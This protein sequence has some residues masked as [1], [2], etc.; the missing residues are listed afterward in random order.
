MHRTSAICSALVVVI[1]PML[2]RAEEEPNSV[3]R[4]ARQAKP[5][6]VVVSVDDRQGDRQ[7]RGTGFVVSDDGLIATSLHVIGEARP[8]WVNLHDDTQLEVTEV[9]ASDQSLD[10][11]ILRVPNTGKLTALNLADH[12]LTEGQ[13]VVAVG[14]PLGL[15]NTV[16]SGAVAG[17]TDSLGAPMWQVA[18]TI[19][20]G[21]SGGPLIDMQSNVHGVVAMK[22]VGSESF[23]FA[24]KVA[25]L[26][27]LLDHPNPIPIERW[28][29]IGQVDAS[30]W[31]AKM[32]ARWRQ[33]SGRLMVEEPGQG[34]GGRALLLRADEA[35]Q[36]P[37]EVSVMVKLDDE[38]GAAGLVFHSDGG[39]RHYGFYPSAGRIRF[40][41]F[42]GPTVFTWKVLE[43][44]ETEAYHRG[45]WN[46]L[47]VRVEQ[48]RIV[49]SVNGQAI[50]DVAQ[51]DLAPGRIGLC[52][53]RN[54]KPQFRAFRFGRSVPSR[55]PS[56]SRMT[57]L[58]NQLSGLGD[59]AALHDIDL[60]GH[61]SE[62]P[63]R[64]T[65]LDQQAQELEQRA[66]DLRRLGEDLHVLSVCDELSQ[67]VR[68]KSVRK[69]DLVRGALLIAKL[70]N[71][72]LNIETYV[73]AVD[74]MVDEIR[75]GFRD[76]TSAKEQLEALD[77]YLFK[78]NGFHG[79]RTEYYNAANSHLDR[80][81]DDR[82]GLPV[83]LSVLYISLAQRLGLN[84]VGVGLPGHFVVRHEPP[85]GDSQLID[86]FDRGNR[87]SRVQAN[88][89]VLEHTGRTTTDD[90]FR[91][92][93]SLDILI[94]ML[95]NL[96]GLAQRDD[97]KNSLLR[98]SEAMVALAPDSPQARGI[99]A[100]H[101]HRAGR[102][103]AAIDD[104]DWILD[105]R[106]PGIDLDAVR[107]M[108][109]AFAR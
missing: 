102:R 41:R 107:R 98:Y 19:E 50:V 86:V 30:R 56:Q 10:L 2:S 44:I 25:E 47:K 91:T 26:R 76:K 100:V 93:A 106:P 69:Q 27:K 95:T 15:R 20:P 13:Q 53:F 38:S 23:G 24:V 39:N 11:A 40:T 36:V 16:V 29:T 74:H 79:S 35:P 28:K 51:V 84:V 48:D 94:R 63:L 12:Q 55:F 103:Q 105:K 59:R 85:E 21:N 33:R 37:F 61:T 46:E 65:I 75:Q 57:E 60:I 71:A 73:E 77:D 54:T 83:T 67:L 3:G 80:A 18:M 87:L 81:I 96:Q 109:E 43:E 34:F 58:H 32:G 88:M 70:D 1:L 90:D 45:G 7:S 9:Y 68:D 52:K 17:E 64:L 62:L 8:V 6:I 5:S 99:R 14:H 89:T 49:G 42:D 104:L 72:E 101:R 4:I 22:S 108:R 92:T 78:Q 97:D 82:E 66:K 31:Q